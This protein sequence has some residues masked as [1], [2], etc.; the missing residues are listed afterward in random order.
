MEETDVVTRGLSVEREVR[1]AAPPES[2]FEFFVDPEKMKLW[3]AV[4]AESPGGHLSR[5]RIFAG[6]RAR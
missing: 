1:I 3:T 6:D 2:V 4:E 5:P